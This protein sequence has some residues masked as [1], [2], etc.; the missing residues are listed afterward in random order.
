MNKKDKKKLFS[1]FPP[2]STSQWEEQITQDLKGADYEKKL[3][4]NT[5]DGLK[6]KPYYRSEHLEELN[7]VE[8]L[9][10]KA[11]FVRGNKIDNNDWL[12]R[13]DIE[14]SEPLIA[15]EVAVDAIAKG[16]EYIGFNVKNIASA[17]DMKVLINGIDTSTIP[18]HFYHAANYPEIFGYF[19]EAAVDKKAKGSLNFDPLGYFLLYNKFYDSFENNIKEAEKLINISLDKYP[20][21]Y[22]INV[23]GKHFHNAGAGIVQEIA[24]S[25]SQANEYL[26]A[27]TDK[28]LAVDDISQ[29]MMFTIAIGSDYFPEIAKIRALRMLW[30]KIVEQYK[31]SDENALKSFIHGE[32][33]K[34]NK[35]IYDPYVNMLRTTTEAM[36]AAI[37]G[38]DSFTVKPFDVTYKKSDAFSNRI[39]RNQ[40]IILK[41]EAYFNKVV[42]P[43]A[44]SYYIENLTDIIAEAAWELFVKIENEG[45]F[46]KN[47]ENGFISSE[48]EKS[49]QKRDMD[50]AMRKK[51]F[52][53]TNIYPNTEERMLDKLEPTAKLS[54]IGGLK[55]YRGT[56]AFEALR[57]AVENHANEGFEVPKVFFFTYGNPAMR[58]ARAGFASGFFG[59]AAYKIFD[60]IGFKSIEEGVEKAIEVKPEIVVFCSSDEEYAEM[61]KAA[62]MI[63]N[64]LPK[65]KV[66][67]AGNPVDLIEQLR[68]DG[69]DDFIHIRTNILET[70][71]HYNEQFGI[72]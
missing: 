36:S 25:L 28:G 33:S 64:K 27:I 42:D 31:P 35:S 47:V 43:S 39:A 55:Q 29:R 72:V 30:S 4:W 15:N 51:T 12:I 23:N 58:K 49:C 44:G 37:G 69:V 68:K 21:F 54:D 59:V 45:G 26:A 52:I 71:T 22:V 3:V 61:G 2:V 53:G 50:I 32:S 48:I 8:S 70:L 24:F 1:E 34:W 60:N 46:I 16:V 6:I 57:L 63:K 17:K 11:P 14:M 56:Q 13:Q 18:V 62:Q 41:E 5:D 20:G 65:T 19:S 10:G 67:V 38:V 7:H 9:P 40:Q 66:I